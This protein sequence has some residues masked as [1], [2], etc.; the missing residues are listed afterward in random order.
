MIIRKK[1]QR[2]P[3]TARAYARGAEVNPEAG[4]P[5]SEEEKRVLFGPKP[6]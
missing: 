3:A 1:S 5:L 4:K 6:G 2:R